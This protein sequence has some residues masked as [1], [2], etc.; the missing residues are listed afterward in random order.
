MEK[1]R[2]GKLAGTSGF[3]YMQCDR[4]CV[5]VLF[6]VERLILHLKHFKKEEDY[7]QDLKD[8]K[9]RL[10]WEINK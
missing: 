4:A 10:F 5:G 1:P 7:E 6:A 8:H 9:T 3:S 2:D